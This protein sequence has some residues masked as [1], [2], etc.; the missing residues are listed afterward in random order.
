MSEDAVIR[1]SSF[2]EFVVFLVVISVLS[3][4]VLVLLILSLT[5]LCKRPIYL[6]EERNLWNFSNS[7]KLELHIG[8]GIRRKTRMFLV[9]PEGSRSWLVSC[10]DQQISCLFMSRFLLIRT[11][12]S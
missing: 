10:S 2:A 1:A 11:A 7:S 6:G 9:Y 3:V 12:F 5:N 8:G 4:V